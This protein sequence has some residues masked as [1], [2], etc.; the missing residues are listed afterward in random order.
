DKIMKGA[1]PADLPVELPTR[2]ELVVNLKT[3]TALGLTIPRR[4]LALADELIRV[5]TV[6]SRVVNCDNRCHKIPK[7]IL[8]ARVDGRS[9]RE[10]FA[11]LSREAAADLLQMQHWLVM[12]SA[13]SCRVASAP[14]MRPACSPN[15]PGSPEA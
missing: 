12:D 9:P 13:L 1:K 6:G 5:R 14:L 15:F 7:F 10:T 2:F 11:I 4:I 8:H 3:A